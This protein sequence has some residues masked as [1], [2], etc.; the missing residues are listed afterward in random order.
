[1]AILLTILQGI[2]TCAVLPKRILIRLGYQVRRSRNIA[3][4]YL[5]R[6]NAPRFGQGRHGK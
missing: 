3:W 5:P 6:P 1:M 4:P 2:G